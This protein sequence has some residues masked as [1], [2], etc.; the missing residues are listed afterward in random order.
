MNLDD[1][2]LVES[3]PVNFALDKPEVLPDG[4]RNIQTTVWYGTT[5]KNKSSKRSSKKK[6]LVKGIQRAAAVM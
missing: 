2:A 4:V 3:R 6:N 1:D 5:C